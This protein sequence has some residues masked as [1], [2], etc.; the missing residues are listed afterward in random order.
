MKAC[1]FFG[2][3][4]VTQDI[5]KKL[6]KVICYLIEACSVDTFY[7]GCQGG[8]DRMVISALKSAEKEYPHISFF[9]VLAYYREASEISVAS[10]N[11]VFPHSAAISPPRFAIDKRNRWMIERSDYAITYVYKNGGAKKYKDICI[12]KKKRILELSD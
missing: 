2:H 7:V 8:F 3:K 1:T 6:K 4:T 11:T 9:V 12:K 10:C 5:S